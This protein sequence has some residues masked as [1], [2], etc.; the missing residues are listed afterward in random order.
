MT[1]YVGGGYALCTAETYA[2]AVHA[3][4]VHASTASGKRVGVLALEYSLAPDAK[5][6]T[7]LDE[8][9]AAYSYL[10]QGSNKPILLL[11]D[12]AGGHLLLQVLLALKARGLVFVWPPYLTLVLEWSHLR[13]PV[14]SVAVSP[15]CM[16]NL[17]PPPATYITNSSTDFVSLANIQHYI[18]DWQPEHVDIDP[19]LG[20]LTGD[21]EKCGP[22][23]V[24]YGGKEVFANE[25]DQLVGRLKRQNV[26]VT[27]IKEPLAPHISPM[28]PSFFGSMATDGIRA[29]GTYIA[30]HVGRA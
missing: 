9:L 19:S 6:P 2:L 5:F 12:S 10:A 8:A 28:L 23:L 4:Q 26:D 3:I 14:A 15:W 18:D 7:Q 16:P 27:V 1:T 25:I 29:I 30:M 13:K 24:H 17:C 11:G 20:P 22:L 21:F